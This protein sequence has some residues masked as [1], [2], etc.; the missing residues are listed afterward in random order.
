MTYILSMRDAIELAIQIVSAAL[1]WSVV[2][3]A[4]GVLWFA[5]EASP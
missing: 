4:I 2:A 5:V 1:L 3:V